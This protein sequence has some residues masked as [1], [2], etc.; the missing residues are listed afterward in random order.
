MSGLGLQC[1]LPHAW[2]LVKSC[3]WIPSTQM[4]QTKVSFQ[5]YVCAFACTS[6]CMCLRF[7]EH[8]LIII[9]HYDLSVFTFVHTLF[10]PSVMCNANQRRTEE[11]KKKK[12]IH[13]LSCKH[14]L[15]MLKPQHNLSMSWRDSCGLGLEP[16][17]HVL[18]CHHGHVVKKIQG[19]KANVWRTRQKTV[20]KK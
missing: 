20:A 16:R 2:T 9:D 1:V 8:L 7:E 15:E 12:W 17:P 5:N 19:V 18:C 11:F 6:V 3:V 13:S 14:A 4:I 10:L